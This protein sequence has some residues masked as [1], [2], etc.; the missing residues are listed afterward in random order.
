MPYSAQ[1]SATGRSAGTSLRGAAASSAAV[2]SSSSSA[3]TENR[4]LRG[5]LER[6]QRRLLEQPDRVVVVDLPAIGV[7]RGEQLAAAPR[8]RPRVV[9]RE[10]RKRRERRR[11]ARGELL[12]RAADVVRAGALRVDLHRLFSMAHADPVTGAVARALD[13]RPCLSPLNRGSEY[14]VLGMAQRAALARESTVLGSHL[15]WVG[16][17]GLLG[18]PAIPSH[19][20]HQRG[21]SR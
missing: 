21:E 7:H 16:A 9:E 14:P 3:P 6:G 20:R 19:P 12:R 15:F 8:P 17:G 5:A 2:G 18:Q 13:Q 11:H 10:P 1:K 4:V